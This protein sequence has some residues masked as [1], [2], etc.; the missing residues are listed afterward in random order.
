M[1]E[2]LL[3]QKMSWIKHCWHFRKKHNCNP[4]LLKI[5]GID[6]INSN[7][8]G[9]N[10]N[11]CLAQCE[12]KWIWSLKMLQP[13]GLNEFCPFPLA[14]NLRGNLFLK[15]IECCLFYS[16]WFLFITLAPVVFIFEY[17]AENLCCL[18]FF[19]EEIYWEKSKGSIY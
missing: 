8:R 12:C 17:P 11:Q 3:L 18:T 7:I 5:R 14:V 16:F 15:F 2:I 19:W 1:W 13:N 4:K 9:G 10:I 6:R